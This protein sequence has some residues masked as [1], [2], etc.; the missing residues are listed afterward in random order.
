MLQPESGKEN[1]VYKD[2]SMY[3]TKY[4]IGTIMKAI[5]HALTFCASLLLVATVN[6]VVFVLSYHFR[7]PGHHVTNLGGNMAR[8]TQFPLMITRLTIIYEIISPGA[9]GSSIYV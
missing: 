4:C 7:K 2:T 6:I 8:F 5:I 1:L 9:A 3:S